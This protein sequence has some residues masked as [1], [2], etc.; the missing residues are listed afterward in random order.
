MS[1]ATG[2]NSNNAFCTITSLVG[3]G[4]GIGVAVDAFNK[5]NT[6]SEIRNYILLKCDEIN[7][8]LIL[9]V[10]TTNPTFIEYSNYLNTLINNV[11]SVTESEPKSDK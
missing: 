6:L 2:R 7:N 4:A 10:D 1:I 5:M 8:N 3:T 9:S 11:K